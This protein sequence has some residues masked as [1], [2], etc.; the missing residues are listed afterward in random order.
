[1]TMPRHSAQS[2]R[3]GDVI[4]FSPLFPL[5]LHVAARLGRTGKSVAEAK[6]FVVHNLLLRHNL[7]YIGTDRTHRVTAKRYWQASMLANY[8]S[9]HS[10]DALA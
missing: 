10:N 3:Q 5:C 6:C 1:M 2:N 7:V 8:L 9:N 4:N